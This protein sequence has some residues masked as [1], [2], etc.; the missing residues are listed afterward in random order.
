MGLDRPAPTLPATMG[1]N[2]T[3][4]VDEGDL[5][6]GADPWIVDYHRGLFT[7]GKSALPSLPTE[8]KLRRITVEEAAAIQTFPRDVA[9]QGA[10][11]AR[12]RQIGNAVPPMLGYHV[13]AALAATL[14]VEAGSGAAEASLLLSA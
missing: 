1:G 5:Y 3:P 12:F 4:I 2:R 11:S 7:E 6:D 8:A 14:G 10:Q 13:A 9:W